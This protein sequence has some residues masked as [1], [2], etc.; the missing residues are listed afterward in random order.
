M[1]TLTDTAVKRLNWL[2]QVWRVPL[3]DYLRSR[4]TSLDTEVTTLEGAISTLQSKLTP[5]FKE[6]TVTA[7]GTSGTAAADTS[8]IGGTVIGYAAKGNQDQFVDNVAIDE[9]GVT[10]LTLAAAATADNTFR[11]A[12]LKPQT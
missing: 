2:G 11:V 8:I 10:T 3:G 6:I 1:S 4:E 7:A 9:T 5:V 12:I